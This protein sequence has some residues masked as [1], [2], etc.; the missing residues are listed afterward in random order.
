MRILAAALGALLISTSQPALALGGQG[1][2]QQTEAQQTKPEQAEAPAAE[3][4]P[5]GA[6]QPEMQQAEAKPAEAPQPDMKQAETQP[7]NAPQ[8]EMQE[9]E[10]AI[11]PDERLRREDDLLERLSVA[12][13]RQA[14]ATRRDQ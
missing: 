1:E 5:A 11:A 7:A 8:P 9:A 12:R 13:Q 3:T 14:S 6:P 4:Q 2:L 10:A